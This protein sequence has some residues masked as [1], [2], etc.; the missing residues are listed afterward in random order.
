[1]ND[2]YAKEIVRELRLIRVELQKINKPTESID[3]KIDGA[4]DAINETLR[5]A[6]AV[7]AGERR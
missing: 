5:R 2:K 7:F 4:E 1:M 3:L 6:Q